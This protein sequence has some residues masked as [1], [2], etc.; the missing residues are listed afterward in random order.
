MYGVWFGK[1]G[2][3]DLGCFALQAA[4]SEDV[5]GFKEAIGADASVAVGL[6]AK[7]E[8]CATDVLARLGQSHTMARFLEGQA[9]SVAAQLPEMQASP[10]P[11]HFTP[12]FKRRVLRERPVR[13]YVDGLRTGAADLPHVRLA[14]LIKHDGLLARSH[15]SLNFPEPISKAS[16]RSKSWHSSPMTCNIRWSDEAMLR[17]RRRWCHAPCGWT[18]RWPP[19]QRELSSAR[20]NLMRRRRASPP[21]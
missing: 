19:C 2:R 13:A 9:A 12:W 7:A 1:T 16:S 10:F 11:M 15:T 5:E 3:F 14:S 20:L 21:W 4:A 8:Q 17:L 6:L 18:A